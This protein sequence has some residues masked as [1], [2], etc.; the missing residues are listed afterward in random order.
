MWWLWNILEIDILETRSCLSNQPKVDIRVKCRSRNIICRRS[1]AKREKRAACPDRLIPHPTSITKLSLADLCLI[2]LCSAIVYTLFVLSYF[3]T[4]NLSFFS[5]L[6]RRSKTHSELCMGTSV[7]LP[8][9]I[10]CS[11]FRL[12]SCLVWLCLS[13]SLV[14]FRI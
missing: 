10:I 8:Y 14:R 1:T 12:L 4:T 3:H 11:L 5:R 13:N 9:S 7:F 6:E 2:F